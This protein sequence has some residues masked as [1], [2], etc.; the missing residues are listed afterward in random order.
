MY[1]IGF[2][3]A[4]AAM[5]Y[6]AKHSP[7]G[8]TVEQVSDILFYGVLGVIIGGRLGYMLFYAWSD[9]IANPLTLFQ[10][11][12]GGMSFHGGLIGVILAL[13]LYAYKIGKSLPELTDFVAPAVPIGLG[14]GRI[15]NFINSELWGRVTDVPWGMVFPN[16]GPLPRHPSQLYEFFLEGIIL[17]IILWIYSAKPRPRGAISGLFL[18][19]YGIIRI[20]IEFF[21]APDVQVGYL[22]FGWVT[23]GQLLSLPMILLGVGLLVWAYTCR[24]KNQCSNI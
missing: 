23:E 22:A 2:A 11:W 17:F 16:G 12:K 6:R 8:F 15:G 24:G 14:V 5:T 3:G 19:C 1:L 21:R 20:T 7:R 9:L 13:W 10:I 18:V 4:W